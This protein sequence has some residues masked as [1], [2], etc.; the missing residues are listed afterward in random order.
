[1]TESLI[2]ILLA[3]MLAGWV[4]GVFG[5]GFAI[6]TT[7]LLVSQLD[8]TLLVFLNISMSAVTSLIAMIS[9]KNIAAIEKK[10]CL[11]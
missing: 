10:H 3:F 2:I 7:L 9:A 5:F 6:A 11:N 8:F 1:M 4:Q